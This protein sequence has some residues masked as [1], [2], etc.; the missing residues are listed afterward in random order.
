MRIVIDFDD[1]DGR[2]DPA[3]LLL[4]QELIRTA[5]GHEILPTVSN[6]AHAAVETLRATFSEPLRVFDFP[7]NPRYAA[8]VRIHAFAGLEPDVVLT[9]ARAG[10]ARAMPGA[11]FAHVVSVPGTENAGALWPRIA[12]S[13]AETVAAPAPQDRPKLAYVS[14]LPPVKSGIAD[15]SAELLPELAKYYEIDLVVDQERVAD[16]RV[17]G[18]P[19]R[20]PDWLR[21]NAHAFDRVLYHVGNS[22]AHQHMFEL[23]RDVPGIVVLHDFFF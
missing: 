14:P 16:P 5:A 22:H 9:L 15:Y 10:R 20:S 11:P 21:A 3:A 17:A 6:R 19:Q 1:G 7:S 8:A 4:A 2:I 12:A 18:F 13:A 23:V